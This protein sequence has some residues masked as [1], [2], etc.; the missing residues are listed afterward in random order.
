MTPQVDKGAAIK[1]KKGRAPKDTAIKVHCN[2][3]PTYPIR[4]R[5]K[6][7]LW[8]IAQAGDSGALR[9]D[10]DTATGTSNAPE[11]VRRLREMGWIIETERVPLIDRDGKKIRVGRYHLAANHLKLV[12]GN[13][14]K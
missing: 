7:C 10:L 9:F 12:H 13:G 6:R 3:T 4:P 11:Y 8:A 14:A 2:N 1:Q 5:D